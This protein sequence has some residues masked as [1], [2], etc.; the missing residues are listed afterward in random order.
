MNQHEK[1]QSSMVIYTK[2]QSCKRKTIKEPAPKHEET[3]VYP[4]LLEAPKF[5][6]GLYEREDSNK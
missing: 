5:G 2:R 4:P 1:E 3:N 6:V